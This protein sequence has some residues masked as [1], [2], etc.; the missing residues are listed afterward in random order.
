MAR[1][2]FMEGVMG[3]PML[4]LM[5]EPTNHLDLNSVLWLEDHLS[6]VGTAGTRQ[7]RRRQQANRGQQPSVVED[8][9][10]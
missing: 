2:L 3:D 4:L 6:K 8:G 7:R 1:A 9:G 10:G 5:D